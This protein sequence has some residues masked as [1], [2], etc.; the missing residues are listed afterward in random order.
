MSMQIIEHPHQFHISIAYNHW[1]KRNLEAVKALPNRYWDPNK[2]VWVVPSTLRVPVLAMARAC[3][4]E[5]LK[6]ESQKPETVGVI[7]DLPELGIDIP[8]Q[9]PDGFDLRDYQKR[10]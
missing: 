4:A 9:H 5:V 10:V 8:L 7:P 2:K 1:R 3:R 6:V